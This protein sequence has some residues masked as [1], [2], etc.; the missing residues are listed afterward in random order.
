MGL[1]FS[2]ELA[3]RAL[4]AAPEIMG[5]N[6]RELTEELR[7]EFASIT[8][9][10]GLRLDIAPCD[11]SACSDPHLV[12]QILRNLLIFLRVPCRHKPASLPR[13]EEHASPPHK[14]SRGGSHFAPRRPSI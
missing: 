7:S 13:C 14:D 4:D 2:S 6:K 10:K 9:G 1:A 8:A 12:G 3:Y 5:A 11:E